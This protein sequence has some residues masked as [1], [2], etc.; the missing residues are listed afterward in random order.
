MITEDEHIYN[1]FT[2]NNNNVSK[3][4][5]DYIVRWPDIHVHV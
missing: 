2:K 5:R 3:V 1:E 4:T